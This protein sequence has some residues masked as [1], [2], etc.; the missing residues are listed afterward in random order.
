VRDATRSR[1][2]EDRILPIAATADRLPD[3]IED[4]R[5]VRVENGRH[6]IG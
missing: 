6:N 3:L 2:N 1:A 4:V 5:L